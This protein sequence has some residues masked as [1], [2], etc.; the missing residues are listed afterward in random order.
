MTIPLKKKLVFRTLHVTAHCEN[1]IKFILRNETKQPLC[2]LDITV[3][4]DNLKEKCII[5]HHNDR[6]HECNC[7]DKC[8]H[9][10]D[11]DCHD[12]CKHKRDC[13]CHDK[14]KHKRDCDGDDKRKHKR[15][16]DGHDKRKHK[17]DCDCHDKCKH[18]HDCDCHDKCKHKHDCD[19]HDK[20]KHKHDCDCHDK[21]KHK[22]DCDCHDKC[23]HKHDCDCHDK[24]KH[25]HDC[26]CHDKCKCGDHGHHKKGNKCEVPCIVKVKVQTTFCAKTIVLD[27]PTCCLHLDFEEL[28]GCCNCIPT[29]EPDNLLWLTLT[30]DRPFCQGDVLTIDPDNGCGPVVIDEDDC[31]KHP[32]VCIQEEEKG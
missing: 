29:S 27:C 6:H 22:H 23:K 2:D 28:F 14:R 4:N 7:H 1:A 18:K 24:C 32:H 9:K 16:C 30:F 26:D 19:C 15:D 20:C 11:C 5:H 8:K 17:H 31:P 25:K 21:C 3:T 12:K 13:G 10:H